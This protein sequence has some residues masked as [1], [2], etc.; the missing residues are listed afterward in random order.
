MIPGPWAGC[1][2][3]PDGNG[4]ATVWRPRVDRDPECVVR[5]SDVPAEV[6]GWLTLILEDA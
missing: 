6:A 1:F 2:I 4:D 5:L 3:A